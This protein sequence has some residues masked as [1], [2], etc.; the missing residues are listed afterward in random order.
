MI[1]SGLDWSRYGTHFGGNL[2]G[3]DLI[4]R[5][6][7]PSHHICSQCRRAECCA[8]RGCVRA[9]W[10]D[11]WWSGAERVWLA[12]ASAGAVCCEAEEQ[13]QD[14]RRTLEALEHEE[15]KRRSAR[16]AWRARTCRIE[17]EER[18]LRL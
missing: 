9:K 3:A 15:A 12:C 11:V 6:F 4:Q 2:E 14:S 18:E 17:I 7:C 1:I 10:D 13:L 8:R 5:G 16:E